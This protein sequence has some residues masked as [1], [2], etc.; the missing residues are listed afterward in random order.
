LVIPNVFGPFGN[1]YY[2]SVI[3]TFSYQ[4]NHDETPKIDID[5]ELQLIYVEELINEFIG[6]IRKHSE[7]QILPEYLVA[8]TTTIRVT[9]IL[10]LL[11]IYK[12]EY[13]EK[14]IIPILNNAFEVN[15][16]NTFRCYMNI[17]DHYPVKYIQHTDDRGLF[18]EIIKL[19]TGGQVSFSITKPGG[20][21]GNHFHT[22]K[23]ERFS[24]IKGEARIQLRKIGTGEV[25]DFFL[26]GNEP[27][28]I[29]MPVWYTHN[30]TNIGKEDL[31]TI[32]WINEFYN[33][34]DPDTYF[35][36]V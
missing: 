17:R 24:V 36:K 8:P 10:H 23:I 26:S 15:L 2:N 30:I 28:Y 31:F 22:R 33:Q 11:K 9:A 27:A 12:S 1:P 20:T 16:F 21:R 5:A 14:G 18:V 3:A 29:D 25:I 7:K 32:F 4:L 19:N 6:K 34:D 13:L 35:E